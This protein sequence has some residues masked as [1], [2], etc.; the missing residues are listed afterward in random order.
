[1][2]STTPLPGIKFITLE[3]Y[4]TAQTLWLSTQASHLTAFLKDSMTI[5]KV[6]HCGFNNGC[7]V[8]E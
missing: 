1:M 8:N 6:S 2:V 7:E 4:G 5:N 3:N